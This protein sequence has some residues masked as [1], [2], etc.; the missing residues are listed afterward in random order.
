MPSTDPEHVAVGRLADQAVHAIRLLNHRTRPTTGGLADPLDTAEIITALASMSGMLPQLLGQLAHWLEAEHHGGRLR[1]DT[2]APRPHLAQTVHALTG[3]L[4]HAIHSIQR[5]AEELDTAHQHAAHLA[6][7]EPATNDQDA[8]T[9][10]TG[11]KSMQISG[12]KSLDETHAS[13]PPRRPPGQAAPRFTRL[14]RQP[15]GGVLSPPLGHTAPRGAPSHRR[16]GA[17]NPATGR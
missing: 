6:T 15:G 5:A 11:P 7:A 2:L 4:Q 16:A 17:T 9:A 8:I 13:H 3:S 14:L 12:A 1:V 10:A